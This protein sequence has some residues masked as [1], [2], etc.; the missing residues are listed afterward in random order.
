M[1][2]ERAKD[3]LNVQQFERDWRVRQLH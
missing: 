1:S 2:D 3:A